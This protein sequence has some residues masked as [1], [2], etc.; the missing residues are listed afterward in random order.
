MAKTAD[1]KEI[2]LLAACKK[3]DRV[4][5]KEFYTRYFAYGMS[6]SSRYSKD[7]DEAAWILNLAFMK[8]FL[9]LKTFDISKPFKPWLRKI[10]VN[11]AI[12]HNKQFYK[13]EFLLEEN[14]TDM[15][16]E[17]DVES[18]MM[19]QDIVEQIRQLTPMYRAVLNLYIIEGFKHTEIAKMLNISTGTSKSNL[20]K[21]K[22]ML[23]QKLK[24][25]LGIEQYQ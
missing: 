22:E 13:N 1:K 6:I 15:S 8:I 10:I 2:A 11:T 3:K 7:R 4:A 12:T 16:F 5:Q 20:F 14:P 19:Y 18:N 24:T 25:N 17:S 23:K 9:N 21:A